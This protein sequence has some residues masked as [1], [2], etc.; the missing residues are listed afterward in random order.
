MLFS[1]QI[2]CDFS[3]YTDIAIGAAELLGF[4]RLMQLHHPYVSK[5]VREFWRRWH[6]SLSTWFRDYFYVSLGGNRAG[7]CRAG[8]ST[9]S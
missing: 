1:F 9:C 2:Y 4:N 6:I 3:G 7:R 5:N 8:A